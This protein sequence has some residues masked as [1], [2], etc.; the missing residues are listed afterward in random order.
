VPVSVRILGIGT[1]VP[2]VELEQTRLGRILRNQPDAAPL[3]RRLVG[4]AIAGSAIERRQTVIQDFDLAAAPPAQPLFWDRSDGRLRHPTTAQRNQV[5][6]RA[7]VPLA[8][9]AA[10]RALGA[11][12]VPAERVTHL[13]TVSCTGFSAPGPDHAVLRALGL[14]PRTRRLHVGFMGCHGAFP[15]LRIAFDACRAD[16]DAVVLVV[17]IELCTLHV[18]VPQT[19][20]DVAAA[21]LF[22]DGAA[23]AVVSAA[24]AP[25]GAPDR[26]ALRIDAL[27][28]VLTDD[29]ADQMTWTI[30]DH[31]FEMR[32]SSYVPKL[33][34]AAIAD[35][36]GPL[37]PASGLWADIPHW[38]IHPGGRAILD[39][40][41]EVLE[42]KPDQL[43]AS[44]S[45]LRDHGNM[46][47]PTVLFVLDQ[48][49][50][51]DAEAG[52][53]VL[54]AAFGPGLTVEA[55]L[56]EVVDR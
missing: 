50:A 32:L 3:A 6:L 24:A 33:L 9:D 53:R 40:V 37:R 55:G 30:G 49:L 17:C 31:G 36:L 13:I 11:A 29:G 26:R 19:P 23:A 18:R 47:S 34:Q 4:A 45:V 42:L 38:A 39:R 41:Q 51:A 56:F 12:G 22:G 5:Y 10:R 48:I 21:T 44:R 52:D 2:S 25:P 7:C 15:A 8:V 14:S 28:S 35:A 1:A 46:S 43:D 27:H 54:A 20:D 16:P